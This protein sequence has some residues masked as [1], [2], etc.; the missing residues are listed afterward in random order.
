[1]TMLSLHGFNAYR[2][3]IS[4]TAIGEA[5][6]YTQNK[7]HNPQAFNLRP[8]MEPNGAVWAD[9]IRRGAV[10]FFQG[11]FFSF[12]FASEDLKSNLMY[13]YTIWSHCPLGTTV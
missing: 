1:M 8:S 3:E 9:P 4:V 13:D 6:A 12:P 7:L 5:Q 11:D 10:E 2:L